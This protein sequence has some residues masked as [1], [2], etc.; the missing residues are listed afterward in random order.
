M[1]RHAEAL[2]VYQDAL[3]YEPDN[4]DLH[5]NLGV[6]H[7]ESGE[8][9]IALDHFEHALTLDPE[10]IQALTNSAVLMQETGKPEF[11][12]TAYER[13]FTVLEK[14]VPQGKEDNNVVPTN[15]F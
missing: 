11:R 13:L 7:I 8:P 1:G 14:L 2:Q 5:Y 10:H 15:F 9:K 6:V 4:P 3:K 12:E